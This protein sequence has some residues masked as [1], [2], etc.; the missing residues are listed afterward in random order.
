MSVAMDQHPLYFTENPIGLRLMFANGEVRLV[1][2]TFL[3]A[4]LAADEKQIVL[5]FG[6]CCVEITGTAMGQVLAGLETHPLGKLCAISERDLDDAASA[7]GA[8]TVSKIR[9]APRLEMPTFDDE[10][11]SDESD[12]AIPE[13]GGEGDAG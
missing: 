5:F 2:S 3:E 12:E 8:V 4:H 6:T 1:A 9:F 11:E 13:P 10:A 7:N